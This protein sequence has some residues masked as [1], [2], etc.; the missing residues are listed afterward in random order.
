[1]GY[2]TETGGTSGTGGGDYPAAEDGVYTCRM[3]DIEPCQMGS[4]DDPAVME[5]KYRFVFESIEEMDENGKPYRFNKITG[6][7]HGHDKAGLTILLDQM[8]GRRLTAA[9]FAALDIEEMQAKKWRVNVEL[10]QNAKGYDQNKILS[11]KPL[12]A[13]GKGMPGQKPSPKPLEPDEDENA[14]LVDPFGD[15]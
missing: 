10:Y 2:F 13:K 12:G 1:M 15:D 5:D 3:K 7:K 4:F 6:R 9:E 14:G 11:V 8:F